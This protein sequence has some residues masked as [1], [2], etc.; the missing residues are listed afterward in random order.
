MF[1][2]WRPGTGQELWVTD[3][4]GGGGTRLLR[5]VRAGP[6]SSRTDRRSE[7]PRHVFRVA[8]Q[9]LFEADDGIHGAELHRIAL[10]DF[11]GAVA[12][13]IGSGCGAALTT[14]GV[15]RL[16]A[17]FEL[18]VQ[19]APNSWAGLFAGAEPSFGGRDPTASCTSSIRRQ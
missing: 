8:D 6:A 12:S 15:P 17:R 10:A 1:T 13:P 5:D 2:V 9:L 7:F 16:G 11:G 18:T 3:G 19:G 14:R 4:T